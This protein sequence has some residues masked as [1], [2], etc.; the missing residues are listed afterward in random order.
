[1]KWCKLKKQIEDKF[2]ESLKRRVEL[3]STRNRRHTIMMARVGLPL[4][5]EKFMICV[6]S[7]G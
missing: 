5:S 6:H 2:C 1:M 4:I 3:R 7:S